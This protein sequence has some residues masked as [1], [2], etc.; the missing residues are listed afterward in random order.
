MNLSETLKLLWNF[1]MSFW[2]CKNVFVDGGY[3]F[4][5]KLLLNA[6]SHQGRTRR[7]MHRWG[8][9]RERAKQQERGRERERERMREK[10]RRWKK[11]E[12]EMRKS[13]KE[14]EREKERE[15]EREWEKERERKRWGREREKP[16]LMHQLVM[17]HFPSSLYPGIKPSTWGSLPPQLYLRALAETLE[18]M[19]KAVGD[20]SQPPF[21]L[22][23]PWPQSEVQTG[24]PMSVCVHKMSPSEDSSNTIISL[25]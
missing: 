25:S 8:R 22:P 7:G 15:R 11:R 16:K 1:D 12:K 18:S 6:C 23:L 14:E 24:I 4:L 19:M 3:I 9:Q 17:N 2:N 13:M 5:E 10:Y 21:S 20:C